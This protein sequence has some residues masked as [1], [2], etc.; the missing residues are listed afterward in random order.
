MTCVSAALQLPPWQLS[1]PLY[2]PWVVN[3]QR[4][5]TELQRPVQ[6]AWSMGHHAHLPVH[7][8]HSIDR[9]HGLLFGDS[10]A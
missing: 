3:R 5:S 7:K 6:Q 8:P 4:G 9:I 2:P 1:C 10:M